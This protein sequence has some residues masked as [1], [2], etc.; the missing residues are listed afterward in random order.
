MWDVCVG[1][2]VCIS[3]M[4]QEYISVWRDLETKSL[5]QGFVAKQGIET[6]SGV[7]GL[8]AP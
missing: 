7:L 4:Y 8:L 2:N 1:G 6:R 5:A 3:Y